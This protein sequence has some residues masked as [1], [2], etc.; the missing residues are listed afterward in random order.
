MY[1]CEKHQIAGNESACPKCN[2][3][4]RSALSAYSTTH[5]RVTQEARLQ[6][7]INLRASISGSGYSK[8]IVL[9]I[10]EIARRLEVIRR[11]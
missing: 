5:I 11:P 3:D 2:E 4:S 10:L 6:A 9:Q 7:A 1:R 8:A